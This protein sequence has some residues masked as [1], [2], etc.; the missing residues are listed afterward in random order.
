MP[1]SA[2]LRMESIDYVSLECSY[3]PVTEHISIQ[4][5][6]PVAGPSLT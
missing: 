1:F 3:T 5:L 2:A 6:D 4:T